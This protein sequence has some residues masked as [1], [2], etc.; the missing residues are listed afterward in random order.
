MSHEEGA[1]IIVVSGEE[2][3]LV[4]LS[5]RFRLRETVLGIIGGG[6]RKE[7]NLILTEVQ[8]GFTMSNIMGRLKL[9]LME[10]INTNN[11][12]L[13]K[14]KLNKVAELIL[15]IN[16][17]FIGSEFVTPIQDKGLSSS[18]PMRIKLGRGKVG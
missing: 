5:G 17:V 6:R 12:V 15:D 1:I 10:H 18:L 2:L 3:V 14:V 16:D 11:S 9:D 13:Q 4:K 7:K 8:R